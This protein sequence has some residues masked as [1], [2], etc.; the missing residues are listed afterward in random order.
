MK[1]VVFLFATFLSFSTFA[2]EKS[3]DNSMAI[4]LYNQSTFTINANNGFF[5]STRILL[6]TKGV[7][8]NILHPTI[9]LAF[10]NK[11]KNV[12]EI[13]ITELD[14]SKKS[15]IYASN[16]IGKWTQVAIAFRYE[17]KLMLNKKQTKRWQTSVGFAASPFYSHTHFVPK[18][19]NDFPVKQTSFGMSAFVIPGINYNLSSKFFLDANAPICVGVASMDG[20]TISNPNLSSIY[21]QTNLFNFEGG[22]P[23]IS[24]RIGIG[25]RI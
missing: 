3:K 25:V 20:Y 13:E 11:R 8:M 1:L 5:D 2:Q 21:Q 18:N 10:K 12:H 4:K 7:D 17:Y 19:A 15:G 23:W 24:F 6:N 16:T 22:I 14:W 9:A